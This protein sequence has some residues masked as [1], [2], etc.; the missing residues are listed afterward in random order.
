MPCLLVYKPKHI[1]AMK[2]MMK[3]IEPTL[4]FRVHVIFAKFL[5]HTKYPNITCTQK[6]HGLQYVGRQREHVKNKE[7]MSRR[8]KRACQGE[9]REHVKENKESMSRRTKRACQGE[10]REHVKE[11]KE[12]MSREHVKRAGGIVI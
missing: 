6:F 11:N 7:S 3:Y 10:Q 5:S 8:T 4:N 1:L 2:L 9:Q 12:S